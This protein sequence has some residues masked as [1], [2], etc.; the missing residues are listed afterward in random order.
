MQN[1]YLNPTETRVFNLIVEGK[2]RNEILM[3]GISTPTSLSLILSTIYNITDEKVKYHTIRDKF[4]ELQCFLRNNPTVFNLIPATKK[5]NPVENKTEY[6]T[7][8][9]PDIQAVIKKLSEQYKE[10]LEV[11]K[12]KLSVLDDI[13]KELSEGS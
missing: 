13:K 12:T 5:G 2:S 11:N 3:S 10:A 8:E 7:K 4:K 1:L 9:K 6:M